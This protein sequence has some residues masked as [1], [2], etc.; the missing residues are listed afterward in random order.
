MPD[1]E[2]I[3]R[4]RSI[5]K[6]LETGDAEHRS[7]AGKAETGM[8]GLSKASPAARMPSDVPSVRSETR[9]E[10]HYS[11]V[12][13]VY[14][15]GAAPE[16]LPLP[17]ES[18]PGLK[19]LEPCIDTLEGWVYLDIE[20]TGLSGAATLAFLVGLGEWTEEGFS[21]DQYLLTARQG[22]EA[23]L[24]SLGK[25]IRGRPVLVTFN[26]KAFDVPI[27]QSRYVMSGMRSPFPLPSHLDFLS[28]TRSMGR[29]APYGQSLKEA[30]RRF[31]G[32]VREGDIPGHMIPA[33][34]FI[35]ERE[36]DLS[37]LSPVIKHN[38]LDVL[39]MACLARVFCLILSAGSL[40][41]P[42]SLT[43]AGK[44][45]LRRGNLDLARKCLEFAGSGWPEFG[46][47]SADTDVARLRLL[48]KVL[49][50]Q[51]DWDGAAAALESLVAAGRAG[52]EDYLSLAR[53][54]ELGPRDLDK[55]LRVVARAALAHESA[56][57]DPP[58]DLQRRQRRLERA[59]ARAKGRLVIPPDPPT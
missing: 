43:G 32:A 7:E 48:A 33:L 9:L 57:D 35:Y 51:S 55:A 23:M 11:V 46:R 31:T 5:I 36:S 58:P 50:K 26:G 17:S 22:E 16:L 3:D 53:C 45:H 39:D 8:G 54:Y 47:I 27:I 42:E 10:Q 4:L 40:G 41:D 30:V 44:I 20:T 37:V 59:I 28:V 2:A 15:I 1:K 24:D 19:S 6:A 52:D 13:T 38:R 25:A 12:T 29:R 14:E 34:Y 49:R 21:I 56:M 18:L